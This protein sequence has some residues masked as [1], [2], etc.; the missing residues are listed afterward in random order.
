MN[1]IDQDPWEELLNFTEARIC[2]G[3]V[4]S[5]LPLNK[6]LDFKLCHARAKDAV[7]KPMQGEKLLKD[8]KDIGLPAQLIKS[9]VDSRDEYLTRPDKGRRLCQ[10]SVAMLSLERKQYDISV[11]VCDGLSSRAIHENCI[12]FLTLFKKVIGQTA[13]TLAPIQI[14]ENGRV[15]IGDEIGMLLGARLVVLL[16]GERPGLS[17][18]NSMGIYMTYEPKVGK[19]DESRN[20]ISNVRD[21]GLSKEVA[22]QKLSYLIEN[23][24][25]KKLSGV[26]LKD[27]MKMEY[28]PFGVDLKVLTG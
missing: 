14:V 13:Y 18:P 24:F 25:T 15:A 20:C 7:L 22:V 6:Y 2:Q 10:E 4:G 5:S 23:S 8:I 21:G 26:G 1:I 28:L 17:S 16:V 19:T 11:V 3:R 27:N 12:P 9:R